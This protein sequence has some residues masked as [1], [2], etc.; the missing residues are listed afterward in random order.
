MLPVGKLTK[1][2]PLPPPKGEPGL[3]GDKGD[4]GPQGPI[5][6][7]GQPGPQGE[8]GLSGMAG[9]MPSHEWVGTSLRF[10]RAPGAWGDLVDLKGDQGPSGNGPAFGGSSRPVV[11]TL[12]VDSFNYELRH[13][14]LEPGINI[15]R[16]TDTSSPVTITLPR[17]V[18]ENILIYIKDE[19]G[20]AQTNNI[21][22]RVKTEN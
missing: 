19:S 14:W 3:K 6:P 2:A 7:Q 20:T 21:T 8:R 16:V 22:V 15:I 1:V 9:T 10:E 11:H 17:S 18:P 13:K 4:T 12:E 5:G